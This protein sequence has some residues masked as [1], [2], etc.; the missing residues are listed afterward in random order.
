[1]LSHHELATIRAAL[2]FWN[3]EIAAHGIVTASHYFDESGTRL[4]SAEETARLIHRFDPSAVRYLRIVNGQPAAPL[5]SQPTESD[6]NTPL[7]T[8]IGDTDSPVTS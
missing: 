4:L 1:M 3:D 2:R 8:V 6:G 5:L 7:V